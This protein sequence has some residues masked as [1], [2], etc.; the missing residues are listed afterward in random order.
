MSDICISAASVSHSY[1]ETAALTAVDLEV[2]KG[3]VF[4]LLGPNGSGKTTLFRLFATLLPLQAGNISICGIDL[5]ND[6][7]S[8]RRKL[9]VTFQSPA[10]DPRLTV[11]ENLLCHGRIY[12]LSRKPLISRIDELLEQFSLS[13]RKKSIVG[14]LSGGLRR[15]VELAKGLLHRP[16]VLLLDEP[17]TGLDPAARRQFWDMIH[18]QQQ[19]E[20][21]T[22]VLTTHLMQEA[23][24]CAHLVLMDKGRVI[25]QGSPQTLQASIDGD[26]LSIRSRDPVELRPVLESLLQVKA[27]NVGNRMCFRVP[28]GA[29]ALQHV[30]STGGDRVLSAEVACPSLEDVF[31]EVTGR[32]FADDV[33]PD[34]V[35]QDSEEAAS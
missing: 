3:T 10:V 20:G 8:I 6:P 18:E 5:K 21:T 26:R 23:E 4:G 24:T 28:D 32:G 19:K 34:D 31:L 2:H 22:V 1:G 14:E 25:S 29:A 16:E 7:A 27:R 12:G 13:D 11:A 9:G 35:L 30:M 33:L 17:S 15:R